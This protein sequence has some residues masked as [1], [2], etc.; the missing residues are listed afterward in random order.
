MEDFI[1]ELIVAVSALEV[2]QKAKSNEVVLPMI[3]IIVRTTMK[4]ELAF[5]SSVICLSV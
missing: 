2:Y 3:L 5:V 4:V 1:Y